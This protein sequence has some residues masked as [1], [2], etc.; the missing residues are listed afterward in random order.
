MMRVQREVISRLE[1]ALSVG[2]MMR[3]RGVI[4]DQGGGNRG[5]FRSGGR[6]WVG[7]RRGEIVTF[8]E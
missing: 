5:V 6:E 4:L 7:R 3:G 1:I 2:S 8:V